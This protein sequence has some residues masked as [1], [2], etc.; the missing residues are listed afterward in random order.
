MN[1]YQTYQIYQS[2]KLHFTTDYD[3][4]KYNYKTAVK[5]DT[6][7]RRKDR[8]FFEK[9]S[10]R[11]D[12]EKLINY[13]TANLVHNPN[14]WIGDMNENI[15]N[16]YVSRY[17]KITY[18]LTQDM[19]VMCEKG[20]TFDQLCTTSDNNTTNPLLEALRGDEIHYES[21]VLVDIMVNFLKKL[22]GEIIDPLGINKDMINLLLKYKLIMLQSPLPRTKLKERLLNTFTNSSTHSNIDSVVN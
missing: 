21:V 10:R 8:Y 1:G 18:M 5:Q 22:K 7:E 12:K 6:F 17:D 11:Y 14:M 13:F 15:Y 19:K 3:A 2:L 16:D 9:L 4:V 20:Y